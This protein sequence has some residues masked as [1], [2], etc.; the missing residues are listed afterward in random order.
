M[1]PIISALVYDFLSKK[2][3]TLAETVKTKLKA[4]SYLN[5]VDL[6]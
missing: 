5:F 6:K 2:D 1:D 4:V 3:K